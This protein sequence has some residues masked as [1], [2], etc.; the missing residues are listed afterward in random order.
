[1]LGVIKKSVPLTSA[2][3]LARSSGHRAKASVGL[4][5]NCQRQSA[6]E[7]S[8][9]ITNREFTS[10]FPTHSNKSH[11]NLNRLAS[12]WTL[13]FSSITPA[14][15][16]ARDRATAAAVLPNRRY[17]RNMSDEQKPKSSFEEH[18]VVPDVIATVPKELLEV[19]FCEVRAKEGN[20]LTPTEVQNE[21]ELSWMAEPNGLYTI[22]MTD[23]DAPSREDPQFREW[24]HWLVVNVPSYEVRKGKVLSAYVGAG[25]PKDTGL[26][27][28]VL[29]VYKQKCRLDCDEPELPNTSADGRGCFKIANF[30]RK[31]DLG[32][33]VA[34]NFFQAE[35]DE[36]VPLL[37]EKLGLGEKKEENPPPKRKGK[38][39]GKK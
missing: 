8:F 5:L 20:C 31:Y 17:S 34:G 7:N 3:L 13:S 35:W 32:E 29:L 11:K 28:Y 23:P 22:C 38:G 2:C 10:F 21:P 30:A 24:H 25:P 36:Y 15:P 33:P 18:G 4:V 1:M 12:S 19:C 16:L 14:A 26:H 37:Y 6:I 9:H 27:R 39:K